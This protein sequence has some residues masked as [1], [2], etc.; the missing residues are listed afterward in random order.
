LPLIS[1]CGAKIQLF[2]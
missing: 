2:I 1:Y